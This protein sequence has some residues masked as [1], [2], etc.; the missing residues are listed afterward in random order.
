MEQS[1]RRTKVMAGLRERILGL[2][3]HK[4][5]DRGVLQLAISSAMR[6]PDDLVG[7]L[8]P[9]HVGYERFASNTACTQSN[10]GRSQGSWRA[11]AHQHLRCL[12]PTDGRNTMK[13]LNLYLSATML[14]LC[15]FDSFC[16][17]IASGRMASKHKEKLAL[18]HHEW[19]ELFGGAAGPLRDIGLSTVVQS[20]EFQPCVIDI[21]TAMRTTI[22]E[23]Q[24]SRAWAMPW[25]Q[26][27]CYVGVHLEDPH[28]S[29]EAVIGQVVKADLRR[30]EELHSRID[31]DG[32]ATM[33]MS[34]VVIA[35]AASTV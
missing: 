1:K 28:Q 7:M 22:G 23:D 29:V 2:V 4:L 14:T 25:C 20:A 27:L 18:T 11:S 8:F 3:T 34:K 35:L 12:A 9:V 6:E 13:H 21:G 31:D 16:A 30:L 33:L 15:A 5:D 10:R 19:C 24:Q 26:A 32:Y 17:S